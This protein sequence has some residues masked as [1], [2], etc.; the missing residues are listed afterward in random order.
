MTIRLS[1]KLDFTLIRMHLFLHQ[2]Y[3]M[4]TTMKEF[5]LSFAGLMI[6][7]L[8]G[9]AECAC[10]DKE[11]HFIPCSKTYVKSEQINF[12]GEQIFILIDDIIFQTQQIS[13]DVNGLFFSNVREGGCDR[14]QWYC[15]KKIGPG[16]Y[17]RECNPNSINIC[18]NCGW[19]R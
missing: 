18:S 5:V 17:C 6:F 7:C 8:H 1:P 11:S 13:S 2:Y 15:G 10:Q 9:Y 19:E 14:S 16:A 12:Y 3:I 4:E